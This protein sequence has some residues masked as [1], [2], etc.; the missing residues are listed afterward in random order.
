M[1][2]IKIEACSNGV[3]TSKE[4]YTFKP[5]EG[6]Y[7]L[8]CKLKGLYYCESLASGDTLTPLVS[9]AKMFKSIPEELSLVVH[10]QGERITVQKENWDMYEDLQLP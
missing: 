1:I 4:K 2:P 8:E 7:F 3:P 6:K 9:L 5:S 10:H